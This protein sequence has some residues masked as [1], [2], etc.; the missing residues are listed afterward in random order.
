MEV[1]SCKRHIEAFSKTLARECSDLT[2]DDIRGEAW[3]CAVQAA[4]TWNPEAGAEFTSYL[5]T[6]LIWMRNNLKRKWARRVSAEA[7]FATTYGKR[8]APPPVI[9]GFDTLCRQVAS[10]LPEIEQQVLQLM[11]R[12]SDEFLHFVCCQWKDKP[13]ATRPR[14]TQTVLQV[15][16]AKYLGVTEGRVSQAITTIKH[17]V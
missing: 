8:V 15:H 3:L 2:V 9:G 10:Q 1:P 13:G 16:Y 7:A 5:W 17:A 11:V 14:Q 4:E 6:R 12:P